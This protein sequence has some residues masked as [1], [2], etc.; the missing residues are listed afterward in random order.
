MSNLLQVR[1]LNVTFMQDGN[2]VRA[3]RGVSF[4]V[5]KGETVAL[6]G[7]SGSG[8]STIAKMIVGLLAPSEGRIL[9]DGQQMDFASGADMRALRRRFQMIFQ[10]PFASLNPRWRVRDIVAEPIVTFGLLQGAEITR[11]VDRLLEVV[12]LSAADAAKFPHEFSGGQRQR[13]AIARAL[14]SKPEFIVCD[15]P[16]SALDVSVQAQ[17][18]NLMRDLQ[19]EFNLTYLLISHDL[20]VVRHMANRIG[21][22]YLGRLVEVADAK[23]LFLEP[24]HPYTRM[25][26]DAVPDLALSGRRRKPVLGEIPNPIDP[27][28]GCAFHPRCPLAADIC[29][30]ETP[31]PRVTPTGQ[32]ACHFAGQTTELA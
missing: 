7:E 25:L 8:K 32:A 27:P 19:D 17:I 30:V 23:R 21:V 2:P 22:L 4:H 15:E 9:F 12:G 29:K 28:S 13:I 3:V 5:E 1:D 24:Q 18:L 20:S 16:T 10:D 11:E 6:V 26:L 31:A 14:S